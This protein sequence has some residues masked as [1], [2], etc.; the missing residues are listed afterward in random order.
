MKRAWNDKIWM[1]MIV[2]GHVNSR[3]EVRRRRLFEALLSVRRATRSR[4][5]DPR[6]LPLGGA[7]Q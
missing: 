6:R 5:S 4:I 3:Q 1:K 7:I 2:F